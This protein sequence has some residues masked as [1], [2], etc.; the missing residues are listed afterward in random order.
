VSTL[1]TTY[2]GG[3]R[4]ARGSGHCGACWH[5]GFGMG[6]CSGRT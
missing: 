1:L 4:G 6:L 3:Y 2:E 5:L